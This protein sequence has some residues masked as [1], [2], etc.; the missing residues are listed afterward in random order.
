VSCYALVV[1]GAFSFAHGQSAARDKRKPEMFTSYFG[2]STPAAKAYIPATTCRAVIAQADKIVT[3]SEGLKSADGRDLQTASVNLRTCATSELS[4][5]ERD[6]AVGLYG[7]A[8][9]ELQRR[10]RGGK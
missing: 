6:R 7:E 1:L 8:V 9:S 10:E 4:R 5:I 2:V 3:S